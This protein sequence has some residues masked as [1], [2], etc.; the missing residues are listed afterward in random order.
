MTFPRS[1]YERKHDDETKIPKGKGISTDIPIS[2]AR[3]ERSSIDGFEVRV[4]R[5]LSASS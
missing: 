2:S 3:A 5:S 1:L 4:K